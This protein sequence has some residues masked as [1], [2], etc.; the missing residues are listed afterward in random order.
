M[1]ETFPRPPVPTPPT[2]PGLNCLLAVPNS[3][4]RLPHNAVAACRFAR[5]HWVVDTDARAVRAAQ[6]DDAAAIGLVHVRS[7]QAAYAGHFPQ[8]FLDALDPAARAESWQR[9]L[10]AAQRDRQ[11]DL[12]A[13]FDGRVG[14]FASVGPSRDADAGGAGELYA[15]YVLPELWGCG[16]GRQLMAAALDTLVGLGFDAATLWVLE[17][18]HRARWFYETGGWSTDGAT[19]VDDGPGFPIAEIRY[20]YHR[21]LV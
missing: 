5:H 3:A 15:I 6:L 1:G 8:E 19:K 13:D 11:A 12:V 17:D 10:G 16:L 21:P 4:M 9:I 18:N 14:G 7:W 20:H 2:A